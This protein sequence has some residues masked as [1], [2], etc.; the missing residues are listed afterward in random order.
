MRDR[1]LIALM[2]FTSA[3][4]NL[5]LPSPT[6]GGAGTIS[7]SGNVA[8][9]IVRLTNDARARNGLPALAS[10]SK[11]MQAASIHAQQMAT[12][13]QQQHTISGAEYPTLE[14]RLQSVGYVYG[15]AAEN[16]AWNQRTPQEAMTSWLNSSG[17][18]A[19]IMDPGLTEMG[20]AMAKSAKGEPY[21]IQ[22]F[23]R[24]R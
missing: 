1:I 24:P 15:S 3:C 8:A 6:T 16:I 9:D 7:S 10:N 13:Q 5:N 23:G 14:S 2:V 22:V 20:A 12:Y 21:W 19:N 11:L 4:A 18:R 17:H